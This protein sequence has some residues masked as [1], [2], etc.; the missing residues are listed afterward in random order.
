MLTSRWA[1]TYRCLL[2]TPNHSPTIE[3]LGEKPART[4]LRLA[5][6]DLVRIVLMSIL[7]THRWIH[8]Q[9]NLLWRLSVASS[10][11]T[12]TAPMGAIATSGTNTRSSSS[13]SGISMLWNSTLWKVFINTV[14]IESNFWEIS[15]LVSINFQSLRKST[16]TI[17]RAQ[18]QRLNLKN[19]SLSKM[20]HPW[21][22]SLVSYQASSRKVSQNLKTTVIYPV[23]THCKIQKNHSYRL[24][25]TSVANIGIL[26]PK[27]QAVSMTKAILVNLAT[28]LLRRAE[29]CE[30][31]ASERAASAAFL[32]NFMM[33]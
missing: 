10:I 25:S 3:T 27:L 26:L 19:L 9:V 15:I 20:L 31:I 23:N 21:A 7:L 4:G 30:D 2:T 28:F 17:T 6:V 13:F 12:S 11:T 8:K 5:F 24:K 1:M 32:T 22:H 18:L 29:L 16:A 33:R 14:R